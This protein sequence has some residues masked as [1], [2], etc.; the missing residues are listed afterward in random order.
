MGPRIAPI[1]P[2]EAATKT[3][4]SASNDD[5]LAG[6][7]VNRRF[8]TATSEFAVPPAANVIVLYVKGRAPAAGNFSNNKG[9]YGNVAA[10]STLAGSLVEV[11]GFDIRS[12]LVCVARY[13]VCEGKA[14]CAPFCCTMWRIPWSSSSW[15]S[16][17]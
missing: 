14:N 5:G 1:T 8:L 15:I 13:M 9:P 12:T 3:S 4:S 2:D 17:K 10:V 7:D 6:E 16:R 11:G